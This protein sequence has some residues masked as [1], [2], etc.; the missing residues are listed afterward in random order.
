MKSKSESQQFNTQTCHHDI[1]H[2][3]KVIFPFGPPLYQNYIGDDF[4]DALLEE[5]HR[6]RS[7]DNDYRD[8]L[9]GNMYFGGSY[10]YGDEFIKKAE[11]LLFEYLN[12]WFVFMREYYSYKRIKFVTN[13]EEFKVELPVLWINFQ[14][15][16]DYNPMHHHGGIVSFV[17]FLKVPK[18]IFK[19]QAKSNMKHAGQL[20]FQYGELIS[21]LCATGYSIVP[22]EN[23]ILMFPST[24]NH[25][26][27]P[28]WVDEERISV[29]G[30]FHI[31]G[32][33]S[34]LS[35]I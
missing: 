20:S 31:K 19:T 3:G 1:E 9:A 33:A 35:G 8:Q 13:A 22:S 32:D 7:N 23:L 2:G 4:R 16:Y 27:P 24:L 17:V 21:P 28:F 29:S 25:T 10:L 15:R 5:G 14:K 30:N 11:P 18:E 6:I 12:S 26:V 34:S